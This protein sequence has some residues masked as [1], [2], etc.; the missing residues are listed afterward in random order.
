MRERM[1]FTLC[2]APKER[3]DVLLKMLA[4]LKSKKEN[5]S[6]QPNSASRR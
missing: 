1:H 6:E 4:D 3:R 2:S 5:G